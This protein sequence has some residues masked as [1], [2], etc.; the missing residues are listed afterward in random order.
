MGGAGRFHQKY[1]G[2]AN[3]TTGG[4]PLGQSPDHQQDRGSDADVMERRSEGNQRST[5]GHQADGQAQGRLATAPVGEATY[6]H[7]P[8]RAHQKAYAECGQRHQQRCHF[9][10]S[11]KKV[12]GDD[13]REKAVDGEIIH[14]QRV[15]QGTGDG[16]FPGSC[17]PRLCGIYDLRT[18][19]MQRVHG[20]LPRQFFCCC[21][22]GLSD[23]DPCGS[24]S[25]FGLN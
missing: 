9:R 8:D 13:H 4:K 20:C 1:R 24:L 12:L 2:G 16:G 3:F 18:L 7:G 25:L 10:L 23:M 22:E 14:F 11:G 15:A 17:R 6:D 21:R 19:R 5:Q